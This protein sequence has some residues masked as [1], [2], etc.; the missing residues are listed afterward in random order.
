M[1]NGIGVFMSPHG[2][3]YCGEWSEGERHGLGIVSKNSAGA[4]KKIFASF[5]HGDLVEI[6]QDDA[7][8]NDLNQRVQQVVRQ[9]VETVC[10]MRA[11][12]RA[13]C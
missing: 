10:I 13:K 1:R 5:E 11:R 7:R 2:E 9:A 6:M 3:Q 12:M 4:C 8:E